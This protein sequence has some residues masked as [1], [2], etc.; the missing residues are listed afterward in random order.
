MVLR[1]DLDLPGCRIANGVVATV[2]AKL[3]LEGFT[4]ER[5]AEDLVAHANAKDRHFSED[6]FRV[7]DSILGGRWVTLNTT[8]LISR[9]ITQT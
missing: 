9:S 5:L 7:F 1:G 2:V 3:E 6:F 4:A 8:C